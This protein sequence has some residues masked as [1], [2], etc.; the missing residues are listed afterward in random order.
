MTT[1]AQT[2]LCEEN[3]FTNGD[4][5]NSTCGGSSAFQ[6]NCVSNWSVTDGSPSLNGY[7][8]NS[9]AWLWSHGGIGEAIEGN[10][11]FTMGTTYTISF[12][13]K[14]DGINSDCTEI[15]AN[16]SEVFIVATNS[17]GNITQNP[18]GEII[19]NNPSS[20][21]LGNWINITTSFTPNLNN[22]TKLWIY[23]FKKISDNCQVNLSIDDICI[24]E[25]ISNNGAYCCEGENMVDNGNFENG[26]N[27]ISTSYT[28]P[29][30]GPGSYDVRT[31]GVPFNANITDHSF[32]QD[33]ATYSSNDSFVVVNGKTQQ[34]IGTSSVI[35]EQTISTQL[36]KNYKLCANFKN[37]P[38]CTFDILPEIQVEING[39]LFP[40]TVINTDAS[41]PCDWQKIEECFISSNDEITIK[42]HLKEDGNG[43]GND[44][45]IDDIAVLE[46]L[47]QN[48]SLTVQNQGSPQQIT[49]SINTIDTADDIILVEQECSEQ[50]NGYQY[51]WFIYELTTFPFNPPIDSA[52]MAPNSWSWSSNLGGFSTQLPPATSANP[53]WDLT[54]TFPNYTFEN[55]KLY[56]IGMYSP[57]CCDSCYD[58]AW[59]YQLTFNG[60]RTSSET[61]MDSSLF[62]PEAKKY[63][64]SMFREFN[65]TTSTDIINNNIGVSIY[66]N[67]TND[68]LYIN[69]NKAIK[70][71]EIYDMLGKRILTKTTNVKQV[72]LS[73]LQSNMYII[74]I[75]MGKGEKQTLK[76]IKK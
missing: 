22:Y 54:T 76:F 35:W 16:N 23:P 56:V 74:T 65:N 50:N 62:T 46:K 11:N 43:D 7:P 48:L 15:I 36:D 28:N 27:G 39:N 10:F 47:D 2:E 9:Y 44:L 26:L 55:D 20:A 69:S 14:T 53:V 12:R 13:I 8:S 30:L 1:K 25:A 75:E 61:V 33:P 17:T 31:D 21:Y 64:K 52:S 32:C 42:I 19:V 37:L 71:Y 59:T 58:E 18:I 60:A 6:S 66:P 63:L 73:I 3:L 45:A 72:D 70:A 34:P 41:N 24:T 68:I 5:S 38:Q 29:L 49:G 57:S 67:P 40:W 51:Y 4:F